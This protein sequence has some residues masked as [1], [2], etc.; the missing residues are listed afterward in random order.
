MNL[1]MK[2]AG[3]PSSK[4]HMVFKSPRKPQPKPSTANGMAG[5]NPSSSNTTSN[6]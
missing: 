1:S 4:D 6:I 3:L 2:E 5:Y